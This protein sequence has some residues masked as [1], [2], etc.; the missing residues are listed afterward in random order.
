LNPNHIF[1][2]ITFFDTG[3][4][5]MRT[6]QLFFTLSCL[7][8]LMSAGQ[9]QS[10]D[11]QQLKGMYKNNLRFWWDGTTSV[12]MRA[13]VSW[14]DQALLRDPEFRA[15]LG[16]SDEHYQEILSSIHRGRITENPEYRKA[17]QEHKDLYE[18]VWGVEPG[19]NFAML[20]REHEER[21]RVAGPEKLNRLQEL[22]AKLES[23]QREFAAGASQRRPV[24]A[25]EDPLSP[26]LRQKIQEAQLAAMGETATI[27]PSLFG[28]L[29]LTDAQREKMEQIKKELEPEFEKH[30]ETY[31][32]NTA[33][34]KDRERAAFNALVQRNALLAEERLNAEI[35]RIHAGMTGDGVNTTTIRERQLVQIAPGVKI[36]QEQAEM[37]RQV[38]AEPESR[39][40]FDESYASGKAFAVLF[41][42]RVSEILTDAQRKRLQELT[43]NPP[44]HA[45]VL[46]QRLRQEP[47]WGLGEEEK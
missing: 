47:C 25:D 13:E 1:R 32:N 43:D 44:P 40:L 22:G 7:L 24:A 9:S 30:L 42:S 31:A 20:S 37:L 18:D 15:A 4:T 38:W 29:N 8:L 23:M 16:I 26:E 10:S 14:C 12:R 36:P 46:I 2:S 5:I 27:V 17:E 33:L 35:R 19:R 45:R 11:A 34:I 41:K 3:E 21:K 6:T 28:V 39:K